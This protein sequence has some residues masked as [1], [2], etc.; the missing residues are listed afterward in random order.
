MG[1]KRWGAAR[2]NV[3][4]GSIAAMTGG[5]DRPLRVLTLVDT[6]RPG[7]AE[8]IAATVARH[9]DRSRFEPI[10]C[11]SRPVD[12][13]SPL[14][15]DLHAS[16]VRLVRLSRRSRLDLR[17][18]WP[19]VVL[20]RREPVDVVH[21]H[22]FGSNV[23]AAL[24]TA[25][26]RVPVFVAHVHS[27]AFENQPQRVLLDRELIARRADVVLTVSEADRRRMLEIG[28]LPP[29]K[30]RVVM[31]GIVPL[32][33]TPTD[34]RAQL[35]IPR[36]AEVVGTLT[37]LRKEKA[38]GVLFDAAERLAAHFPRL[39]VLIA[40]TGP[41]EQ[42]LRAEVRRRGLENRVLML[43]FRRD[44]ADVLAALDVVVLSSD[45]EGSPLAVMEAMAA[46]KPIVA[47][48]VGGVPDLVVDGEHGLLVPPRDPASL[49]EALG[50]LLR[51]PQLRRTLGES[52]RERQR[53]DFDIATTVR[54]IEDLYE[55]L[56][57]G[58]RQAW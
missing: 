15:D 42:R 1:S 33:R 32:A 35:G 28:G 34:V 26:A 58:P 16:G 14:I 17:A 37:V 30:L 31:N 53:R 36:D 51:D 9:L 6:L 10:V 22:M 50:R 27:W 25:V 5:P 45:R 3:R 52:G 54:K 12:A 13:P 24:L 46:G 40:G 39:R 23:W 55:A 29:D 11:V 8:R 7:G 44:V 2:V 57:R 4:S 48:R 20:L 18:W 19:L 56:A 41:E 38:H 43:G 49:A 21:S 47:T